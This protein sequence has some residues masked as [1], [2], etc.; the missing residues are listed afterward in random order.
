[1]LRRKIWHDL[2]HNKARS[3]AAILS[4]AIGLFTVGGIF[5]LFDLTLDTMDAAHRASEPSHLSLILGRPISPEQVEEIEQLPD[6]MAA[7]PLSQYPIRYRLDSDDEMDIATIFIRPEYDEQRLDKTRLDDGSYPT[8]TSLAV[9]RLTEPYYDVTLND[10]VEISFLGQEI[11]LPVEGVVRHSFVEPPNF[12]GQPLFFADSKL[13]EDV[14]IPA[15]FH[16]QLLVTIED[17]SDVRAQEVAATLRESLND[18]GVDVLATLYQEPDLHWGRRFVEGVNLVLRVMAVFA[19]AMSVALIFSIFQAIM[20][21][22][23]DRIGIMKAIGVPYRAILGTYLSQALL[24]SLIALFISLL[25]ALLFAWGL[26]SWFLNLFNITVTSFQW[27]PRAL[28]IQ[29]VAALLVPLL[30]TLR[31]VMQGARITVREA[32]AGYGL[33]ANFVAAP[34]A[35][36]LGQKL[37]RSPM[38][39]AAFGNLFRNVDRVRLTLLSLSV[40]GVMFLVVMSLIS[41]VSFTLDNEEARQKYDIR[42]G[43]VGIHQ[44]QTLQEVLAPLADDDELAELASEVWYATGASMRLDG[45]RVDDSAGLG[46]RVIGIDFEND[47]VQPS[48]Y[49][50]VLMSGRWLD[51][52]DVGS[53]RVVISAETAE[54]HGIGPGDEVS[55]DLGVA[56]ETDWEVIGT[57]RTV[58]GGG[59]ASEPLYIPRSTLLTIL[60]RDSEGSLLLIR[61]E[62]SDMDEAIAFSERVQRLL[63]GAD[64]NVDP[65]VTEVKL[66]ERAFADN[67][68]ASVTS[69]LLSL[70][71]MAATVGGIGLAGALTINVVERTKEIGILR[72]VGASDR[73]ILSVFIMESL[74]QGILSWLIAV[75]IALLAAQPLARLMG[76]TLVQVDLDYQFAWQ[77]TLIWLV[78]VIVI[79]LVAAIAPARKAVRIRVRESL[80]Y[81]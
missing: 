52:N 41:S 56:G 29:I 13:L 26:S 76:Q 5:G 23:V 27:S 30:A 51:Q 70:A 34:R 33:G 78:S 58:Y 35:V 77:A 14:G 65:Y 17:Y 39:A 49:Q 71:S 47:D 79:S 80:N 7:D 63:E 74:L 8:E 69:M 45:E 59:F 61:A 68:F 62:Q 15:G 36:R 72:S 28:V 67:Q 44:D 25:P 24:L 48:F 19:L 6:V 10:E 2:W 66:E 9:E 46:M 81:G 53:Q 20:A 12:G 31:P 37:F 55:L 40:A 32:L 50:P 11:F 3:I 73:A 42:F 38:R 16:N 18:Q 75:P 22:Q 4:I 60:D 64:I 54:R 57:F 1:M 43:L 21:Q